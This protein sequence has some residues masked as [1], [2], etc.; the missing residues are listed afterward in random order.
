MP[1]G[2]VATPGHTAVD[3]AFRAA[4]G[5]GQRLAAIRRF[6]ARVLTA[7]DVET[8]LCGALV[9]AGRLL[10][11]G[12]WGGL[13]PH[14]FARCFR[15]RRFHQ[16]RREF[17]GR[18]A[19]AARRR[20]ILA[21]A[22][23]LAMTDDPTAAAFDVALR[24]DIERRIAAALALADRRRYVV[25]FEEP[26]RAIVEPI[27]V[28]HAG[29]AATGRL[30]QQ[31]A[32]DLILAALQHLGELG[33][34]YAAA[35]V[36]P[37]PGT[38]EVRRRGVRLPIPE[39]DP[40]LPLKSFVARTVTNHIRDTLAQRETI[41]VEPERLFVRREIERARAL[42]LRVSFQDW[43]PAELEVFSM[44]RFLRPGLVDPRLPRKSDGRDAIIGE[45]LGISAEVV[46]TRRHRYQKR[47][48]SHNSG[49]LLP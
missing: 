44:D 38:G 12:Y 36:A 30:V 17:S 31:L 42:P 4:F 29:D 16:R 25:D 3:A 40:A 10:A 14:E 13:A 24:H 20:L 46:Q 39:G 41:G 43:S 11:S 33:D 2:S 37:S 45:L 47:L 28:R 15:A 49:G 9:A 21:A 1:T 26:Y 8:R 35:N 5:S 27:A 6:G 19:S 48:R 7:G 22:G 32:A 18:T 23:Y 34:A